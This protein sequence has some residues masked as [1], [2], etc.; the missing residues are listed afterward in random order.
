MVLGMCC[1]FFLSTSNDELNLTARS[2][3]VV[4]DRTSS[5]LVS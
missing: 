4:A 5:L 2:C 1:F 3:T